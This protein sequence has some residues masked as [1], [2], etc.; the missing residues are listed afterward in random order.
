MSVAGQWLVPRPTIGVGYLLAGWSSR[1]LREAY[2]TALRGWDHM[3]GWP[4]GRLSFSRCFHK[5]HL[6]CSSTQA[7]LMGLRLPSCPK[8]PHFTLPS[9]FLQPWVGPVLG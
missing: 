7:S 9:Y 4:G 5:S 1:Q 6:L 3:M 2:R 8:G